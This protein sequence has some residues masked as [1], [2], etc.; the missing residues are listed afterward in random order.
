VVVE[1]SSFSNN[2]GVTFSTN[3][4]PVFQGY[5]LKVVTQGDI[6]LTAVN[7]SNN[8][9]FGAYLDAGGKVDVSHSNFDNHTSGSATNQL[10]RG[11][12][13][14]SSGMVNLWNV[15]VVNNQTFGANIQAGDLVILQ[16]VTATDNGLNGLD[17]DANC[18]TVYVIDGNYSNNGAYGLNVTN[19]ALDQTGT[20]VFDGNG[21]G[22][23]FEDPGTCVF[24]PVVPPANNNGGTPNT[25][26]VNGPVPGQ[27]ALQQVVSA[28][29]NGQTN[30]FTNNSSLTRAST[31][32]GVFAGVTLNDFLTLTRTSAGNVYIGTFAGIYAYIHSN[33]GMQIIAF[34]PASNSLVMD[35]Q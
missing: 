12:E 13:V 21:A 25:P 1:D 24:P 19:A 11:L 31:V 26:V 28:L 35:G 17:V 3:G 33:S 9:L 4:T 32:K 6:L 27:S 2:R 5:G 14:I 30:A 8:T 15:S 23:L 34:L 16:T 20:P 22:G 10:G 7:A 18:K 29:S